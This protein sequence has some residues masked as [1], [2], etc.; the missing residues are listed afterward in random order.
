MSDRD[1]LY[2]SLAT[3][4]AAGVSTTRAARLV[5]RGERVGSIGD[6]LAWPRWPALSDEEREQVWRLTAL[7]AARDTLPQ[8]IDGATL[9]GLAAAVGEDR[10][11]AVLELHPGG[12]APLP[13]AEALSETGRGIAEAALPAPLADRMVIRADNGD[14]ASVA[15]AEA[16]AA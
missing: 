12:V 11:E 7:V 3:A 16:I 15:A 4:R 14:P 10:L 8:V 9:R 5:D 2:A 6:L 13:P 1:R